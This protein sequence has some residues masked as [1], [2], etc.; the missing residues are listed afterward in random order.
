[1]G[2]KP[3]KKAAADATKRTHYVG[4]RLDAE[5]LDKVKREM[6]EYGYRTT[7][8]YLRHCLGLEQ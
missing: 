2:N 8:D 6:A 5:E 1:M 7:S 3:K 4:M